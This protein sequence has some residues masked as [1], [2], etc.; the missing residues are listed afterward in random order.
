MGLLVASERMHGRV[1]Q[2][3]GTEMRRLLKRQD[4]GERANARLD[5]DLA[6]VGNRSTLQVIFSLTR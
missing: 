2:L 4:F 1:T 6:Y 3:R 5:S